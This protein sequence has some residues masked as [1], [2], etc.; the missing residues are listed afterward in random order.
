MI[1]NCKSR[2]LAM[3][4]SSLALVLQ[5]LI[6]ELMIPEIKSLDYGSLEQVH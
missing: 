2:N 4:T 6:S 5:V 1:T 3:I